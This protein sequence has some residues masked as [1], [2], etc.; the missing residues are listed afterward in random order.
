MYEKIKFCSQST[1]YNCITV[2]ICMCK[3]YIY[4][5]TGI[6][7]ECPDLTDPDN[8][9]VNFNTQEGSTAT[10]TCNT[11]YQLHGASS[12][13]CQSDGTWSDSSPTCTRMH[14]YISILRMFYT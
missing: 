9:N 5:F 10:Y 13:T 14:L 1:L 6:P 12:R 3:Q 4:I 11:G 2:Y 8:G 7:A